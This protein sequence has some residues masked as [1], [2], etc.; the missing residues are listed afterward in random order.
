MIRPDGSTIEQW[1]PNLCNWDIRGYNEIPSLSNIN[2]ISKKTFSLFV[3]KITSDFGELDILF[4]TAAF[5][6]NR[7]LSR[8]YTRASLIFLKKYYITTKINIDIRYKYICGILIH[9]YAIARVLPVKTENQRHEK[10]Y[11]LHWTDILL[12]LFMF[13]YFFPAFERLTLFRERFAF[14]Y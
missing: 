3:H 1:S 7:I 11:F 12:F 13:I 5:P 6:K 8:V 9:I 2:D 4:K 14:V 10:V